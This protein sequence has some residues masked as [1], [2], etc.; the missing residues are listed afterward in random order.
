[1]AFVLTFTGLLM[2][3]TGVKGTYA[4]FG[5]QVVSD[6]T[7][8]QPFTYWVAAILGVGAIGYIDALRTVSR[9]FLALILISMIL[10]NKGFFNQLMAALKAGP[11]APQ[12]TAGAPSA[13]QASSSPGVGGADGSTL[14]QSLTKPGGG[15]FWDYFGIPSPFGS[16]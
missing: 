3:V 6:F 7:G 5:A 8:S 10:A 9:M 11:I 14:K 15:G 16:K 13:N 1:M 12:S 4:Q 2:I